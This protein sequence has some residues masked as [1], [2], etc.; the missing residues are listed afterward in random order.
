M[1]DI[2]D[3]EEAGEVT[4]MKAATEVPDTSVA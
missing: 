2:M 1:G 3:E 4:T